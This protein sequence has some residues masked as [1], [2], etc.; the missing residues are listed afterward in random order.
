[1]DVYVDDS[2]ISHQPTH[3]KTVLQFTK[4][5]DAI[6]QVNEICLLKKKEILKEKYKKKKKEERRMKRKLNNAPQ[7][8]KAP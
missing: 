7:K 5:Y 8:S 4:N 1:L 6:K 3:G 2:E